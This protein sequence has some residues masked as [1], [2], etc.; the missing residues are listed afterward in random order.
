M[1]AAF[2]LA[3]APDQ[4]ERIDRATARVRADFTVQTMAERLGAIY[5]GSART[6]GR[7]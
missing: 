6:A 2:E 4:D 3:T 7:S 5:A 1:R